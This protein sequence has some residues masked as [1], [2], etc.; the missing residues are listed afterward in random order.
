MSHINRICDTSSQQFTQTSCSASIVALNL[1]KEKKSEEGKKRNADAL[2][3]TSRYAVMIQRVNNCDYTS[4]TKG[5]GI[6]N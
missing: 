4:L 3:E 1:K 2:R 6:F 5:Q